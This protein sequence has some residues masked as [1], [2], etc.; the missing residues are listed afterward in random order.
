MDKCNNILYQMSDNPNPA[1]V[2]RASLK[3]QEASMKI[4]KTR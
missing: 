2:V 4:F 1:F 3:A